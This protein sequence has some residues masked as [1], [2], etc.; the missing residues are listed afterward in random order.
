VARFPGAA[1]HIGW[2]WIAAGT[3]LKVEVTDE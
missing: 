1:G 2:R 3:T